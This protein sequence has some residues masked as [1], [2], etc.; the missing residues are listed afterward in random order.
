[1][2][3]LV[4]NTK[5]GFYANLL[6]G[7]VKVSFTWKRKSKLYIYRKIYIFRRLNNKINNQYNKIGKIIAILP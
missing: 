4:V 7:F 1:M 2:N 6:V 3:D 5:N